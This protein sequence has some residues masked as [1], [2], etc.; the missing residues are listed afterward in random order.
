MSSDER[1]TRGSPDRRR[2]CLD[3]YNNNRQAAIAASIAVQPSAVETDEDDDVDATQAI[4]TS[5]CQAC[6][7][8]IPSFA[9]RIIF[10][11]C[12]HTLCSLCS[13]KSQIDRECLPHTCPV[14]N[15]NRFTAKSLY[16]HGV[17]GNDPTIID[18]TEIGDDQ[19]VKNFLPVHWL[20]RKYE[21]ELMAYPN[22]E[23]I[24]ISCC[25]VRRKVNGKLG[26]KT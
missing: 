23:G 26:S 20:R 6:Y 9:D 14:V 7:K 16:V 8:T 21:S 13:Y 5:T 10:Q 2:R 25:K 11:P 19:Y 22:C 18:N 3:N 4:P 12:E 17:G 1:T 15:C 24:S